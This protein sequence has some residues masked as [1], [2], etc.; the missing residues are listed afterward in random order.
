M[1]CP[2]KNGLPSWIL[3]FEGMTKIEAS[4]GESTRRDSKCKNTN[5]KKR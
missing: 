2:V 3:S 1:S 4:F 5:K